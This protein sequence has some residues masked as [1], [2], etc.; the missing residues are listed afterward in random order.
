MTAP[1]WPVLKESAKWIDPSF[2]DFNKASRAVSL[3]RRAHAV[4]RTPIVLARNA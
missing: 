1:G 3:C 4:K 2:Q